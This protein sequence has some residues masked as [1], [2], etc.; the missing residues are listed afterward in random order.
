MKKKKVVIAMSG[1]VDS[2]VA[3]YLL[4]KQGY[5][6]IGVFMQFWAP[7]EKNI[8][9]CFYENLCCSDEARQIALKT[10]N[11]LKIPFYTLNFKDFFKKNIVDYFIDEYMSGKTPNP[12]VMCGQKIKFD[13]L[14]H[15]AIDV[16]EAD[17]VATGHYVRIKCGQKKINNKKLTVYKLLRGVD[18]D[19]DQSYFLYTATQEVLKHFLFPLG[20]Y[21][22]QKVREIAKKNKLPSYARK[23]SQEICFVPFGDYG[24]FLKSQ[25]GLEK[26]KPGKIVNTKGEK[27][28][29]HK[30]LALYTVGQRRGIG[31]AS[32]EPYYVV[33]TDIKNN[34][35]IVGNEEDLYKKELRAKNVNWISGKPP[36]S[37]KNVEIKIRYA[38]VGQR[39]DICFKD[40]KLKIVFKSPQRA[41]T[42]GQSAVIY[43]GEEVLGGG[44]IDK[45]L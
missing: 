26:F 38:M 31:I 9:L 43:K 29:Q 10:A 17:Y 41:V 4:K 14:F 33:S 19:K 5:D 22:K 34:I 37:L 16:F 40:S 28:G 30:G 44:V 13:A 24:E 32:K 39:A 36:G 2:S 23:E 1:G 6:V 12:C 27:I 42:Q 8:P 25:V 45:V 15:K 7:E 21:K 11:K 18:E 3:A 20:D 35:L